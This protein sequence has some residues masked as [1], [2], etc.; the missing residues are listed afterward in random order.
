MAAIQFTRKK[1]PGIISIILVIVLLFVSCGAI[2][3]EDPNEQYGGMPSSGITGNG[4][5][6]KLLEIVSSISD[7]VI[8]IILGLTTLITV[9]A[10]VRSSAMAQLNAQFGRK[11][12][13]ST[14]LIMILETITIFV[15]AMIALPLVKSVI[16]RAVSAAGG[17]GYM[18]GWGLRFPQ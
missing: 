7:D 16:K 13:L 17:T 10:V 11:M 5:V 6:N 15:V 8:T 4:F 14:E 2:F 9:I 18:L 3:A 12:G 1:V